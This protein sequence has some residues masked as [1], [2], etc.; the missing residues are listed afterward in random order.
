MDKTHKFD[1]PEDVLDQLRAALPGTPSGTMLFY[2]ALVNALK[3]SELDADQFMGVWAVCFHTIFGYNPDLKMA[4]APLFQHY[5]TV[6][7][8]DDMDYIYQAA[9]RAYVLRVR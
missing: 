3:G 7:C 9:K 6:L 2:I 1:L 8:G 4:F 5:L